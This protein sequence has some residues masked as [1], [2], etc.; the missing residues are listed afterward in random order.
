MVNYSKVNLK[1]REEWFKYKQT[2]T[3]NTGSVVSFVAGYNANQTSR[4][5]IILFY[6]GERVEACRHTLYEIL[7]VFTI[8]CWERHH[9]FIQWLFPNKEPSQYNDN[10]PLLTNEDIEIFKNNEMLLSTVDD[11]VVEFLRTLGFRYNNYLSD[12]WNHE[13]VFTNLHYPHMYVFNHNH[14]RITR[15]IK[16]LKLIEHPMLDSVYHLLSTSTEV[17]DSKKYWKEAYC[18]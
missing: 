7:N 9:D 15:M 16:F 2:L 12:R 13:Y 14:L 11:A 17:E 5:D 3:D 1:I 6:Y 4:S 8:D 10:A 18:G